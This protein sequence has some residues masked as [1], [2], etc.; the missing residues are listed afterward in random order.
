MIFDRHNFWEWFGLFEILR[1]CSASNLFSLVRVVDDVLDFSAS[2]SIVAGSMIKINYLWQL[3]VHFI[4][5]I[6]EY[7]WEN[8]AIRS[9]WTTG[10]YCSLCRSAALLTASFLHLQLTCCYGTGTQ[11]LFF[12]QLYTADENPNN[13]IPFAWSSTSKCVR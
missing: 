9:R 5:C 2:Y 13:W 3:I 10:Q 4:H 8:S 6:F 12:S 11:G 1:T 7:T